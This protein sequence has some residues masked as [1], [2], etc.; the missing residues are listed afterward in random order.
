MR[1][2]IGKTLFFTKGTHQHELMVW[3][4]IPVG[5]IDMNGNRS[6]Q[7]TG[8]DMSNGGY[9]RDFIMSDDFVRSSRVHIADGV[10]FGR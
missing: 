8:N 5:R 1:H 4:V 6:Y 7:I 9:I 3:Q 10:W 2:L